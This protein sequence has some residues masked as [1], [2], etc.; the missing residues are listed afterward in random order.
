MRIMNQCLVG[1]ILWLVMLVHGAPYWTHDIKGKQPKKLT[2][3]PTYLIARNLI[4]QPDLRG[5]PDHPLPVH[6]EEHCAAPQTGPMVETGHPSGLR[7]H[8]RANQ[9]GFRVIPRKIKK[10]QAMRKRVYW[11]LL[12]KLKKSCN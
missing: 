8:F 11:C 9:D 2:T 3:Y 4:K 5:K 1:L 12:K 7:P 10:P 6:P